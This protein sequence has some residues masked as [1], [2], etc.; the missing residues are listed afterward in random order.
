MCVELLYKIHTNDEN[1][2]QFSIKSCQ[3]QVNSL[4]MGVFVKA[5]LFFAI[6]SIKYFEIYSMVVSAGRSSSITPIYRSNSLPTLN[7]A[8]GDMRSTRR[9]V[10]REQPIASTLVGRNGIYLRSDVAQRLQHDLNEALLSTRTNVER[11]N[12][13]RD[14]YYARVNRVLV[15]YGISAVIGS[16]VGFGAVK[17]YNHTIT[18]MTTTTTSTTTTTTT[19]EENTPLIL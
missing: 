2:F 11:L 1:L 19:T 18:S 5:F 13:A 7:A 4:K 9:L 12:P 3:I 15:R 10:D 17:L 16:A 8:I 6:F 14:G